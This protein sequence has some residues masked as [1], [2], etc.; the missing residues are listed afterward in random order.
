V[1]DVKAL[2][3]TVLANGR[4]N[5]LLEDPQGLARVG[6]V[7]TDLAARLIRPG[8]VPHESVVSA[9]LVR[10]T[11]AARP[12]HGRAV[13]IAGVVGLIATAG[14]VAVVG[15]VSLVALNDRHRPAR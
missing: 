7:L 11:G 8:T 3:A 15:T 6:D 13:A 9:P 5:Q 1:I 10:G 14:A 2:V 12:D 4:L